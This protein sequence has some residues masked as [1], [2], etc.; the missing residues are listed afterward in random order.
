[1]ED[2]EED[3]A[4]MEEDVK[5]DEEEDVEEDVKEDV[6]EDVEKDVE[7]MKNVAVSKESLQQLYT[8][9]YVWRDIFKENVF[10]QLIYWTRFY[11]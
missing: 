3:M 11:Y 8:N 2:V 6:E 7:G 9:E 4:A 1:M 10:M 5:E